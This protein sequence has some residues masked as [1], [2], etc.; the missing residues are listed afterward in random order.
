MEASKE[1]TLLT[2]SCTIIRSPSVQRA[3]PS[4]KI[5]ISIGSNGPPVRRALVTGGAGFVGHGVVAALAQHNIKARVLDVAPPHP[6]W[7]AGVE[8]LVGDVR[9]RALVKAAA[10][11]CD[12]IF[13]V[14]GLWDGGP[15]GEERMRSINIGGTRAVLATGKPVVYTSSSI[16]C[17]FGDAHDFGTEDGPSEDP[18]H[19]IRGTGRVY[20]ETKLQCERMVSESDGWIVN[21]D[22]VIGAGDV[23]GVVT[24]PLLVA[25][26][27]PLFL[28]P[29][30]GK[31]FVGVRDVGQGHVRA[32]M[33]GKPGRRYLLGSE[34]L[35][36]GDVIRLLAQLMNKHHLNLPLPRRIPRT[37]LKIPFKHPFTQTLGALDQ[38][39]LIRFRSN[40]RARDELN[41]IPSPV[42]NS[43]REMVH[44]TLS[45]AT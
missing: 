12:V 32:L 1:M 26:R 9:D 17:G 23:G 37:L 42:D 3:E 35:L 19:P 30:G 28:A 25:A 7:P 14:A 45:R 43:L 36:Y 38:M 24:K 16:T 33:H 39:S 34:N 44:W 29:I 4:A 22:Y 31:C 40:A 20:R 2:N 15:N 21:P 11:S 10:Q 18:N 41:W 5:P 8:H 27:L 6:L 13:H